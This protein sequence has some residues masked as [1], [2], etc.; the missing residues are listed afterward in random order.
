[1]T[2]TDKKM[3]LVVI[4]GLGAEPLRRAIDAGHA[5][6]IA[7]L[8]AQGA[9]FDN[10]TSPFPSLTP[11]CL[12]TI[13]TGTGPDMHR[14][15]SLSWYHRGERRFVEYGSSFSASRI[16]GA[17]STIE[18]VILNLNH[19]HLSEHTHTLFEQAQD[20]G[21]TAASINFL[22]WRG[23]TRHT[24]KHDYLPV[25]A[26]AKQ[27]KVHAVYGPDHFYFGELYGQRKPRLPQFGIKRPR[28]WM[29]AHAAR[30]LFSNTDTG[31]MLLYL[32]QHDVASHKHGP[33]F[34]QKAIRVA[35]RAIGRAL[36]RLGG[37]DNLDSNVGIV[38]CADH[39]QTHVEKGKAAQLEEVFD[40]VELFRGSRTHDADHCD[41]AISPSNRVAMVY[42]LRDSA[43]DLR[44]IA[45]RSLEHA[46]SEIAMWRDDD[47]RI[48]VIKG[49]DG[50]MHLWRD[51]DGVPTER[52]T[53][54]GDDH[55]A[56]RIEG[57]IDILDLQHGDSVI[58]YGEY[59]DA[60]NRI[61]QALRCVNTGDVL[62]SGT[63]GWE[64]IDIGGSSHSGGSH[65]SLH[66]GDS[67]APLITFGIQAPPPHPARL[68]DVAPI[69]RQ[70]LGIG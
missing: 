37:V 59:P 60:L 8:L 55:D 29:G 24:M 62:V 22:I 15:P 10:A 63:P 28:D 26:L 46:G 51:D 39:G 23:R 1:V 31:F 12:S 47:G 34:T 16:E 9:T 65:G 45:K 36:E 49:D 44:W 64:Y 67:L 42:R 14:V 6:T 52:C 69:V 53:A 33:D 35:D 3:L 38:I 40:D 21:I 7:T 50:E 61:D 70:H 43:P 54:G 58:H 48:I 20:A 18:D 5:P 57:D 32:G 41:I 13:I 17:A 68:T 11:V 27:A 56:W 4:D 25:S 66:A 30:W 19:V 2:Q